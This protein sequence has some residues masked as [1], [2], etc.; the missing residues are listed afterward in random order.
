MYAIVMCSPESGSYQVTPQE[1]NQKRLTRVK[2]FWAF[3]DV[4]QYLRC[5]SVAL[6]ITD[7]LD[8]VCANLGSTEDRYPSLVRISQVRVGGML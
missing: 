4:G 7:H 6:Q 2:A 1:K 3:P 5:T 8:N